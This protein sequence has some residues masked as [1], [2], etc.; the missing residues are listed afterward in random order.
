[1]PGLCA[2][3]LF[4]ST[5]A[6]HANGSSAPLYTLVPIFGAIMIWHT[7]VA[8]VWLVSSSIGLMFY[9]KEEEANKDLAAL[10]W[11]QGQHVTRPNPPRCKSDP[12][13]NMKNATTVLHSAEQDILCIEG[14]SRGISYSLN[15]LF[16]ESTRLIHEQRISYGPPRAMVL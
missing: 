16:E 13:L 1:M 4:A 3:A 8:W 14:H 15:I 6:A 11:I 2:V 12:N 9:R 7:F 10:T 5:S